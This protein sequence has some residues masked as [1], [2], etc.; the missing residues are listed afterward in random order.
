M[1]SVQPRLPDAYWRTPEQTA[2]QA[3]RQDLDEVARSVDDTSLQIA[4]AGAPLPI[5]Y[6][7]AVLGARVADVLVHARKLVVVA[8]WG[9]G[10]I[11]GVQEVRLRDEPLPVGVESR[12]Y[13][14]TLDQTVDSWLVAA[15]AAAGV[16]FAD[17]FP[18][19][20]YS[21]F[22]VAEGA[23]DGFPE[24]VARVRGLK[25]LDPRNAT[26]A[27]SDNPALCLAD[28]V[29]S[30]VYGW[31]RQVDWD[32]VEGAADACDEVVAGEA[33]R[34]VGLALTERQECRQWA[35]ALRTYAG[36]FLVPG[37]AGWK[38]I[39]DRPS[40]SVR[41]FA[42]ADIKDGSLKL[43]KRGVRDTPTVVEV[44]YTE[45]SKWPWTELSVRAFAPGV[46]SGATPWRESV[47]NLPGVQRR[48]QAMRE[49]IER[50]NHATLEDLE[51]DWE[52]WDEALA[53]TEGDVVTVTH[54]IGLSNKLFR[55]T[56]MA[57]A[58]PGRWRLTARE[59]DAAAYSDVIAA[60]PST[61]DT[62][63][64]NPAAPPAL[65]GLALAEE[66]YQQ[67]DG[68]YSSRIRATWEESEYPYLRDYRVEVYQASTLVYTTTT[69]TPT[70]ATP[71]VQ[72][73][74][75]YVVRVAV[76]SAIGAIGAWAQGNLV[77][78]GNLLPPGNVASL[79]GF[80]FGGVVFLS[81][82]AAVDIGFLHYEVRYGA[83]G[84]SWDDALLLDLVDALTLHTVK[85]PTGDWDVLV[86]AR[87]A[88]GLYSPT[89]ARTPISV[90][91][92]AGSFLVDTYHHTSPT[93][94][95]VAE[96]RLARTDATRY[97]VTEDAVAFGTKFSGNLSTYGSA[98]A[99]YHSSIT[100]T[101]TGESEDFGEILSGHWT[102]EATIEA[103]SGSVAT[104][105]E[106]SP[107]GSDWLVY[108]GLSHKLS[109]R[110]AR[111]KHV[112]ETTST[113]L[114]RIP[115]QAVR[116]D[117]IAREEQGSGTSS[118]SAAT[119][120]Y[121][122][123]DYTSVKRI[124]VLPQGATA[125]IPTY[126]RVLVGPEDSLIF[127]DTQIAGGFSYAIWTI[128]THARVIQADDYL[129]YDVMVLN[130][131]STASAVGGMALR[132]SDDSLSW[133][134]PFGTV[135]DQ[136]GRTLRE[137]TN[138]MGQWVSRKIPLGVKAG[139]TST[140]WALFRDNGPLAFYKAAY[141]NIR[142]TD[143]AGTTRATIWSAG[144]PSTITLWIQAYS[145]NPSLGPSNSFQVNLF[146][147]S[148]ARVANAFQWSFSGV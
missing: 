35:E 53:V 4:G 116:L 68:T 83:V 110:F 13:T 89:A 107:D 34:R 98:L 147:T 145:Q 8:V 143:G 103:L 118:A 82:P 113:L 108:P 9:H 52:S 79:T 111:V 121:L 12:H 87:D 25:V 39:P 22:R 119:N 131:G 84:V 74:L 104:G 138:I 66:V 117:V 133:S 7:E 43:V 2:R 91:L 114:A 132:W 81:W 19:V 29:S 3:S 38:L 23:S 16:T 93:L 45:R 37:E 129:E 112:A 10:P 142:V 125:V 5:L 26:T 96:Y 31:G 130:R 61:P 85:I 77:A 41:T 137:G 140:R 144:E 30:P 99:T 73:G 106:L 92:D 36:C 102:G 56:G 42:A 86:K 14:G 100:S 146:N 63:L 123:N 17:A 135:V 20:A 50:L 62:D 134:A 97:F 94:S 115:T 67:Q 90:T 139:L 55:V 80:E 122:E 15:Y 124:V 33:R 71:S 11:Q 51:A 95:N 47:I 75:E 24:F 128:S 21:V 76:V 65:T 59:Y 141:R 148:G 32:S 136:Y 105:L 49:A 72:E 58:S 70:A 27:W 109:S 57:S 69:R 6:G 88:A 18:G 46:E 120:I 1:A 64:P 78:L 48:S 101:W 40:A 28:F 54:P 127:Q 60:D 126:D 44:R